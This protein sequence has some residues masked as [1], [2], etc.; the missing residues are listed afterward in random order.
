VNVLNSVRRISEAKRASVLE[1]GGMTSHSPDA[2]CRVIPKRGHARAL[3][4][5]FTTADAFAFGR[6]LKKL[7][8]DN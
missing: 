5:G 3:Q 4:N 1:C 8:P 6:E 2:T 7:H